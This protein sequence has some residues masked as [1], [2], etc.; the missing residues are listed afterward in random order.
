MIPEPTTAIILAGGRGSRLGGREKG[1]IR[2]GGR[3]LIDIVTSGATAVGCERVVIAGEITADGATSVQEEPAYGGPVAGL[4][5]ALPEARAEWIMLL[6]CDLPHAALLC[7]LLAE[8][9]RGADEF[10]GLA[11]LA[12][13]RVQWLAGIYRRSS[14]EAA[15][16]RIGDPAGVPLKAVLGELRLREVQDPE[17]LSRDLDTPEDLAEFT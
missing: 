1:E 12:E 10:D 6:G 7:R 13:G 9:F 17:G 14:L 5:A 11:A 4:A 16:T 2:L 3:R 8:S 15:L